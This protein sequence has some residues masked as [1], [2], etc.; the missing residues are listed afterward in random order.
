MKTLLKKHKRAVKGVM[1]TQLPFDELTR[2]LDPRKIARWEKDEKKAMKKRGEHLDIYQLKIDKGKVIHYVM[3][4]VT[5]RYLEAPTMAEI[6]LNLT[7]LEH[8]ETGRLGTI[9]WIIQGINLE[10]AQYVI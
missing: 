5:D 8:P 2:S 1:D 10:D 3:K 4:C 7:E 6:R 9:S